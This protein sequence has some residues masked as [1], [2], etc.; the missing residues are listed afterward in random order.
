[1][2]A[3]TFVYLTWSNFFHVDDE[4][5]DQLDKHRKSLFLP[6]LKK[7]LLQCMHAE[8]TIYYTMIDAMISTK[9]KL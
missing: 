3:R 5:G 7:L 2:Y 4:R 8:K 6:K 1:M 9:L